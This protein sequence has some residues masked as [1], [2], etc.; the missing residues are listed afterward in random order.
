MKA[1]SKPAAVKERGI[2]LITGSRSLA[3][4]TALLEWFGQLA[5]STAYER[6][7]DIYVGDATGA[8]EAVVRACKKSVLPVNLTVWGCQAIG[9]LRLINV[10]SD[11]KTI[12]VEG[13]TASGRGEDSCFIVRDQQMVEAVAREVTQF[14]VMALWDGKSTGTRAT[15]NMARSF[16]IPGI[17]YGSDRQMLLSWGK[18]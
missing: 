8:D 16:G 6:G 4:Q 17:V 12:L 10:P 5:L 7:W 13:G 18:S 15:Y 9:K 3:D 2:L 1:N 11:V 14:G